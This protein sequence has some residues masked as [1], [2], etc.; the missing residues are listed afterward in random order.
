MKD[1]L[2]GG[3]N[4][5]CMCY[6]SGVGSTEQKEGLPGQGRGKIEFDESPASLD[7]WESTGG[8]ERS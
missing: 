8:T 4:V 3:D 5:T 6:G 7:P 2:Q 1:K